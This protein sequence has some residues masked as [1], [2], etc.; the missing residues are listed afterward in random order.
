MK[1]ISVVF[2]D[3]NNIWLLAP[4]NIKISIPSRTDYSSDNPIVEINDGIPASARNLC[5]ID[6]V[7]DFK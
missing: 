7:I 1:I 3:H 6:V 4:D 5:F 2:N